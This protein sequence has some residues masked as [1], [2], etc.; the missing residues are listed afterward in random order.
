MA[1]G[2]ED[3]VGPA[4]KKFTL[5]GWLLGMEVKLLIAWLL[6][7][8]DDDDAVD[9]GN[10]DDANNNDE[11]ELVTL[12]K[13]WGSI[14]SKKGFGN[15]APVAKSKESYEDGKWGFVAVVV[16]CC[17]WNSFVWQRNFSNQDITKNL[18][19]WKRK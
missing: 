9:V 8:T 11:V 5:A 2:L 1:L 16:V 13:F 6:T 14:E 15:A 3:P 7:L 19:Y 17:C 12:N 18:T 10:D 4:I